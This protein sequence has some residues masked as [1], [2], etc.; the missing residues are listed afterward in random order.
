MHIYR[1][2]SYISSSAIIL[3]LLLFPV[4]ELFWYSG[5][6]FL[7]IVALS[8]VLLGDLLLNRGRVWFDV[9]PL[10]AY[11]LFALPVVSTAWSHYP[12]ETLFR[13]LLVL[14]NIAIIYLAL[15][16]NQ[17]T[18][19][20]VISKA[21][22]VVPI[23]MAFVFVFAFVVFGSVRAGGGEIADVVSSISNVGPAM[24]VICVPYLFSYLY[25]KKN[26]YIYGL[27]LVSSLIVVLLSESRG[28][29]IM[30]LL[31]MLFSIMFLSRTIAGGVMVLLKVGIIAAIVVSLLVYIVDFEVAFGSIMQRFENSQLMEEHWL[32]EPSRESDDYKRALMYSE[33]INVIKDS[34]EFGIGY[35]VLKEYIYNRNVYGIGV[36]SHNLIITVWGEMGF[37]GVVVFLWLMVSVTSVL[38]VCRRTMSKDR[39]AWLLASASMTSIL[40]AV[41]HAQFR[42]IFS[43]PMFP[44]ILAQAYTMSHL[45]RSRKF[46]AK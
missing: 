30:F 17:F 39:E 19:D 25:L 3:L 22:V 21:V 31:S 16:A 26:V 6:F 23:V 40:I 20:N 44:I 32:H 1:L 18:Y 36:V 24:A 33:G 34:P 35:G 9:K 14:S 45:Y 28:G 46:L 38:I 5:Y 4:F 15:R 8:M 11:L 37:P 43:N 2:N 41:I 42:P 7:M 27:S 29:I 10:P 13:G 12:A